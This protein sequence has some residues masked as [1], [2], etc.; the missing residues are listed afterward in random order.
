MRFKQKQWKLVDR[1]KL[2][3]ELNRNDLMTDRMVAQTCRDLYMTDNKPWMKEQMYE[4][5]T[6]RT[7]LLFRKE[8]V[9]QF[10]KV[11]GNVKPNIKIDSD[12]DDKGDNDSLF[13]SD[14]LEDKSKKKK[15]FVPS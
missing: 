9:D 7:L 11:L 13:D 15:M 10:Q 14:N 8:I 1:I 3:E 5:F 6:P 2:D 12:S 4:I